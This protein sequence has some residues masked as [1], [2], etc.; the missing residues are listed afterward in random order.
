VGNNLLPRDKEGLGY[1]CVAV[2]GNK[3]LP[4]DK[5]GL[6]YFCVAVVGNK[7]LPRDKEVI[8]VWR[9]WETNYYRG[10][11]R[12]GYF[13]VVVVGYKLLP[14]DKE[15]RLFLCGGGEKQTIT[16]GQGG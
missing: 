7:L 6:G 10:T 15:G 9:W 4:R 13:C 11:R 1:F 2:V 16:E 5:E 3:L 8:C 14:R 12:V